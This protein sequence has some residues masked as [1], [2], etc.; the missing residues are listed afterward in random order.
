LYQATNRLKEAEPLMERALEIDKKSLGEDHP[1]VA[2]D[3]N[4]L[5]GLYKATGRYKEAEP[6]AERTIV[7]LI[8]FTR[9]TG[10]PHPHLQDAIDNYAG[11]LDKMGYSKEEIT[12]KLKELA[13]EMFE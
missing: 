7:I 1:D 13:P 9:K 10:H 8:E 12:A 11:L 4:N 2:I 6:L 3:L 5:A